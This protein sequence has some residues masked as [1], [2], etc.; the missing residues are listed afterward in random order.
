M[1]LQ[2]M[3]GRTGRVLQ[4]DLKRPKTILVAAASVLVVVGVVFAAGLQIGGRDHRAATTSGTSFDS[5]SA[6]EM[7]PGSPAPGWV[8]A[9][10]R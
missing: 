10:T 8:P 3:S 6:E 4:F 1:N 9:P 5:T 2:I 7:T